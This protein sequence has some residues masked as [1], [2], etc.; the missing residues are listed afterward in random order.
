MIPGHEGKVNWLTGQSMLVSSEET[1]RTNPEMLVLFLKSI[2]KA[3]EYLNAT[4]NKA[5]V[6]LSDLMGIENAELILLLQ[7]N[8]YT[9]KMDHLFQVGLA[10]I[11]EL[12]PEM[13]A[14]QAPTTLSRSLKDWPLRAM[15]VPDI[16]TQ[17]DPLLFQL[18]E[19]QKPSAIP[20]SE[21]EILVEDT[22]YYPANTTIQRL[23]N[24]PLRYLIVDD[25]KVVLDLF[26]TIVEMVDGT[27]VGTAATGAEAMIQYVDLLPDVIVM[28]ISM[29]DMNGI[30]A[31]E[32]ILAMNPMANIIV[33]SGNNYADVRKKVFDLG[34][35]LFIG[36][37]FHLDRIIKVLSQVIG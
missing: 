22:I 15:Y 16:L 21:E 1:L 23:G 10:S 12:F 8:I 37:P 35:K 3:T 17:I 29:P 4:M 34:V 2:H 9:M 24:E 32:R 19:D 30:E 26:S 14:S 25:T 13:E 5:A 27:V 6:V 11:R 7:K 20:T 36:K 31:I 18:T 33:I 28:D